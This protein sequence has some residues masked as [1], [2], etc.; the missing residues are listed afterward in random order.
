M[1][2]AISRHKVV[3]GLYGK[4]P[5]NGSIFLTFVKTC[6]KPTLHPGDVVIMDN[7]SFHK[8]AE[9]EKV[10]TAAGAELKFLPPYSP[11]FSP[12]EYMWS[13][14][15][16]YIRKLAPSSKY[17]LSKAIDEGFNLV[18]KTHLHN[19]YKHCGY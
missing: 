9:V 15:K 8:L 11:E 3:A 19:W 17:K 4:W 18:S 7:V 1:I 14:V 2:G 10:I 13:T 12:I 16:S 5:V 6:L